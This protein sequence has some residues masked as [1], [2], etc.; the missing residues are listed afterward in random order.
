MRV[1]GALLFLSLSL[2]VLA[3]HGPTVPF[4]EN[5][6]QWPAQVLYRANI[7]GGVLFVEKGALTYVLKQGGP[8]EH[9]A[10]GEEHVDEPL[11]MHAYRVTFEG[12]SGGVL[13]GGPL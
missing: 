8:L 10:H 7:P 6:G 2:S 4:T 12:A 3:D 13:Q 1:P 11:R 5:K 9:H